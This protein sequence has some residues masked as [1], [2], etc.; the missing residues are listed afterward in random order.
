MSFQRP[1]ENEEKLKKQENDIVE[2]REQ[3]TLTEKFGGGK[4]SIFFFDFS[5]N[6]I[7]FKLQMTRPA[8]SRGLALTG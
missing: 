8:R 1:H 4:S 6:Q 3:V 5:K 2:I 7:N